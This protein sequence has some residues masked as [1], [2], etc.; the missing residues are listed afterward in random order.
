MDLKY[1]LKNSFG[2]GGNCTTLIF[3]YCNR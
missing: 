3:G 1:V 2:F